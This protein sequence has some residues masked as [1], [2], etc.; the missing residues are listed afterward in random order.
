MYFLKFCY[1]QSSVAATSRLLFRSH[2]TQISAWATG[3]PDWGSSW[4]SSISKRMSQGPIFLRQNRLNLNS[5]FRINNYHFPILLKLLD[6]SVLNLN[7][8]L[9]YINK[10]FYWDQC[11][12]QFPH[13]KARSRH[14]TSPHCRNVCVS[15]CLFQLSSHFNHFSEIWHK[16]FPFGYNPN[17]ME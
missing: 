1:G 12:F 10:K 8:Q 9:C 2:L 13:F 7:I 5:Y 3:Y 4:F 15:V 6:A 14:M 11:C 17:A 16:N